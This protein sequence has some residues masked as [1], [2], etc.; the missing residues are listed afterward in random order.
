MGMKT[1]Y[2]IVDRPHIT[3]RSVALSYGDP[4]IKED[5]DLVRKYTFVVANDANK[6]EIKWAVEQIYNAGKKATDGITVQKVHITKI[7]GKKKRRGMRIGYT[8]ERK[9]AIVTLKKG[10]VLEDYGV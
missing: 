4:R 9:K 10:Q 3:E 8:A 5:K 1:P 7:H 2:D 6:L